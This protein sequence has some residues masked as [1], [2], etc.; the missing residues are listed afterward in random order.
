M[1]Y[2][3]GKGKT[4]VRHNVLAFG[5]FIVCSDRVILRLTQKKEDKVNQPTGVIVTL[6]D[7]GMAARIDLCDIQPL[8]DAEEDNE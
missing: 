5:D 3:R 2:L 7:E 8:L 6:D 1:E 4:L